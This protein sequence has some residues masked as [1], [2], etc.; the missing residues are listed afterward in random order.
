LASGVSH[1][2]T[3]G[4][5]IVRIANAATLS[6]EQSRLSMFRTAKHLAHGVCAGGNAARLLA[7]TLA[8]T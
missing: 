7:Q 4:A 8:Q 2:E 1:R 3:P 6:A 5:L